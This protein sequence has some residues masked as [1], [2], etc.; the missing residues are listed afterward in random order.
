MSALS[1]STQSLLGDVIVGTATAVAQGLRAQNDAD[2]LRVA[3]E[4][5][6]ASIRAIESAEAMAQ[7]NRLRE[8]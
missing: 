2:A 3:R 6:F 4:A 5:L 7:F 1:P 8:D